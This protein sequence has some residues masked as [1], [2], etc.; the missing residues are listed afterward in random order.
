[1]MV[2]KE[3]KISTYL[4]G[5]IGVYIQEGAIEWRILITKELEKFGIE[6]LNPMGPDGGDRLGKGRNKLQKWM[7]SGDIGKV[8]TYVKGTVIP[9][10]LDMVVKSTFLTIFVPE[11]NGYEIC[12]TYGE[13][14]LQL[15]LGKPIFI[16]TN[17]CL[18][19]IKLPAWLIG[20]STKIFSSWEEYLNFIK[21]TY[22]DD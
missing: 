7:E 6:V 17:R 20:C 1:M 14:T 12:G 22:T 2:N 21:D 9:P 5:P 11:D 15:Y 3:S 13:A 18:K 19:P 16:I 4:A 8:R 10:D